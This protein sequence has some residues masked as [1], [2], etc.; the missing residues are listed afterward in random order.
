M[1]DYRKIHDDKCQKKMTWREQTTERDKAF[2]VTE[3]FCIL[4]SLRHEKTTDTQSDVYRKSLGSPGL[5]DGFRDG[6][7]MQI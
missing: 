1:S 7:K 3:T 5:G 6:H 4:F 2:L